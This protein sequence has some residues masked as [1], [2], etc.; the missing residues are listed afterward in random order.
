MRRPLIEPGST[1]WKAAMLPIIPPTL[2]RH[3][4]RMQKQS[5]VST[6]RF[7]N[8]LKNTI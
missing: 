6:T 3:T 7:F 8:L 2:F 5:N 1:A 4:E